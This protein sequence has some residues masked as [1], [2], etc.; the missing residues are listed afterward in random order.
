MIG[1]NGAGLRRLMGAAGA[2]MLLA[3]GAAAHG[4]KVGD[5]EV[6]HPYAIATPAAAKA[7]AGYFSV[8]NGGSDA[9]R[10][11]A[12]EA[13]F[14]MVQI[15]E[16]ETDAAGVA[17]MMEVE[18]VEIPAGG[19]VVLEPGGMHV[20]FMGLAAPLVEGDSIDAT[21]VFEKAGAVAVQFSV[22][23]RGEDGGMEMEHGDMKH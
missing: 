3:Q 23:A 6:G 8:T 22:E 17:R 9:D 1:T 2:A 21:L 20:M 11:V 18:A 14:P 12:I 5:L 10:L 4:F 19:T 15:H 13:D 7:G 16:T